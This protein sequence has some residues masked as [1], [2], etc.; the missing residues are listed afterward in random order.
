MI[1]SRPKPKNNAIEISFDE[2]EIDASFCFN[3]ETM[4]YL[5]YIFVL[6]TV[7]A[8]IVTHFVIE[9]IHEKYQKVLRD[10]H[11]ISK[12]QSKTESEINAISD[13]VLDIYENLAF[14]VRES[15]FA[16]DILA[17]KAYKGAE[18]P[19][20]DDKTAILH[21]REQHD[22]KIYQAQLPGFDADDE[23]VFWRYD[24]ISVHSGCSA[25][26]VTLKN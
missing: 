12:M 22:D 5:I 18:Q 8:L 26:T 15:S 7:I 1:L 4:E 21:E 9:C 13:S 24:P 2:A 6:C 23:I 10:I 25:K 20:K 19:D 16:A 17:G 11:A 14:L 3:G